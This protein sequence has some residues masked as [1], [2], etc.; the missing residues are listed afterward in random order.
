MRSCR[1][2]ASMATWFPTARPRIVSTPRSVMSPAGHRQKRNRGTI[3]ARPHRSNSHRPRGPLWFHS[4]LGYALHTIGKELLNP[5]MRAR[6]LY[7]AVHISTGGPRRSP[8]RSPSSPVW[9][10]RISPAPYST[11]MVATTPE[12]GRYTFSGL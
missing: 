11:W 10:R 9:A 3:R 1:P 2:E 6:H 7:R 8:L 5:S 12:H 4:W